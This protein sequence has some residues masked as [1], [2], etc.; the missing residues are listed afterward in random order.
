MKINTSDYNA[1]MLSALR[2]YE[3]EN[4]LYQSTLIEGKASEYIMEKF[5]PFSD[6]LKAK[7]QGIPKGREDD[8]AFLM[9]SKFTAKLHIS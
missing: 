2:A 1:I 6:R 4:W 5:K 8:F 7:T 9:F 3:R